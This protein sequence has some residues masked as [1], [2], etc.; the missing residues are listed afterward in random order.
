M[1]NKGMLLILSGP[2]GS[3]KDTV[4]AELLKLKLDIIQSVSMTTRA[5]RNEERNGVDYIFVD[6]KTFESAI[7]EKQMLEFAKYGV[8]YYGTP[9]APVDKWLSEGRTVIL[10][11]DIQGFDSIKKI[12]P[13]ALSIFLTPPSMEVLEKRLRERGSEDEEDVSRRLEI[14]RSEMKKSRDYDYLVIN[15]ELQDAVDDIETIIR[16]ELLKVSRINLSEVIFNV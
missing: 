14:A 11:I 3:G 9:K 5:P 12:Y 4:I 10:K 7:K 8:N 1:R 16:A 13:D 2:S 6:E 15:D